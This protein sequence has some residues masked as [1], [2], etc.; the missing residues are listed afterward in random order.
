LYRRP[1]L[2]VNTSCPR[3]KCDVV[4]TKDRLKPIADFRV[5]RRILPHF[6]FPGSIYFITFRTVDRFIFF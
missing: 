5:A 3:G 4:E 6:E 1:C 2:Y